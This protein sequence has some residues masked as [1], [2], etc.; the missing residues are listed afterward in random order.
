MDQL[1]VLAGAI[2]V[3]LTGIGQLFVLAYLMTLVCIL[4]WY[5]VLRNRTCDTDEPSEPIEWDGGCQ[6]PKEPC[7]GSSV[8]CRYNTH[9]G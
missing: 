6:W 3:A 4:Y 5:V 8:G 2:G 7:N 9:H 1:D